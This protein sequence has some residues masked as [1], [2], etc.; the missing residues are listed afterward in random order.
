MTTL[1]GK[2]SLTTD[3]VAP[4]TDFGLGEGVIVLDPMEEVV[5]MTLRRP[6]CSADEAMT[7]PRPVVQDEVTIVELSP[8]GTLRQEDICVHAGHVRTV[9][10]TLSEN[11]WWHYRATMRIAVTRIE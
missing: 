10:G 1:R 11:S 3:N 2:V 7:K 6:L 4:G 5:L 8:S 9:E